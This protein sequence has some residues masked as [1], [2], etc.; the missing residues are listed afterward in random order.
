MPPAPIESVLPPAVK[1]MALDVVKTVEAP[2]VIDTSFW[3]ASISAPPT[4]A[5]Q[6]ALDTTLAATLPLG[7]TETVDPDTWLSLTQ[8][9]AVGPAGRRCACVTAVRCRVC[10]E[11][12]V[13][14]Y[15]AG[16][17]PAAFTTMLV[18]S[19]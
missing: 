4:M 17:T 11:S 1:V 5:V 7:S 10:V 12:T 15:I 13:C 9:A 14:R 2:T 16:A 18:P 6:A 19:G 8:L 3:F